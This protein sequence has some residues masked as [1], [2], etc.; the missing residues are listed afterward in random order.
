MSSQRG[1]EKVTEKDGGEGEWQSAETDD[2]GHIA[3][4]P[5]R[6]LEGL[7]TEGQCQ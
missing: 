6:H 3:A 5:V 7:I 1:D 4:V 2:T